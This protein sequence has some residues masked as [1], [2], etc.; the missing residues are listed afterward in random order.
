MRPPE[1]EAPGPTGIGDRAQGDEQHRDSA[2]QAEAVQ[3]ERKRFES[4][5]ALLAM[6]GHELHATDGGIFIVRRWGLCRDLRDL[7]AVEAFAKQV[8]AS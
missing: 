6:K 3:A 5:R 2:S 4:L 7:A 8:G 1:M